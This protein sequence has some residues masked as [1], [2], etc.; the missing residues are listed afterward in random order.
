MSLK[1]RQ[2]QRRVS[3]TLGWSN[4]YPG[5]WPFPACIRQ[6]KRLHGCC[7]GVPFVERELVFTIRIR[8]LAGATTLLH[9]RKKFRADAG[10][11]RM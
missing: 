1:R 6:C 5:D 7:D 3:L 10:N 8:R 11:E 4:R 2:G 9:R